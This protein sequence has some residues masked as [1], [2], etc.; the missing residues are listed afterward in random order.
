MKKIGKKLAEVNK[1]VDKNKF[2]TLEEAMELVKK[3]SYTKFDASVD[4][5]FR[6]NLDTRK[7]DQQLRGSVVLPHGTGKSIRVLVATD[8]SELAEKAKAAGADLVY[9][10][11]ELEHALKIDQFDFDV[12]VVEP[13]LMPVLG[14]YGKKLGP[15]GLMPN[16]K[17]GTVT[18]TPDKAV[19]ELKKGKANYRAD[20]YGIV[21]SLIGKVSM[22]T[23]ALVD[24]AQTLITLIKKLK[25]SV[26]KGTYIKNLTVSASMGPSIKIKL[27]V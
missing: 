15:K 7:A 25:P 5:A 6:L 27:E 16:P 22:Q 11:Q 12:I 19:L 3:T 18:P 2:Y 14:K 23:N 13:K 8:S 9:T 21:H 26:V 1:L 17:T 4:L 24:N 20:K 10:T